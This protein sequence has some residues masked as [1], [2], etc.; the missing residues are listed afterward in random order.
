MEI[1]LT[2]TQC[3]NSR[4]TVA[5]QAHHAVR[6]PAMD[7]KVTDPLRGALLGGRYRI[8]GRLA[9]GGMA[10]VYQARDER[11][12]R[13]VAI[14]II[15][16]DH[17][18]DEAVLDRLA[19]EAKTVA[20]L[21]HPNIVAVYDQGTH[22][23]APYI[24]MEYVRGRTLR[25]MLNDRR[26]LDPSESLAVLEQLLA[27]LAVAH[28]AG[29]V[30][31]DV[32]PENILI[33]PPPNGSG[34]LVDAVVK[35]ADFGLAHAVEIGRNTSGQLLATAEYV[36]PELVADGRADARAD[37]YS[38]GIVL[39]EML[40]GRVPFDGDQ[41]SAV[42]WQHVDEDVPPPSRLIAGLPA[43]LDDVV[44][45]AT[46]RDPAGR[47]RDAAEMLAEIQGAREDVGAL[48]GPTR[49]LAHPTVVVPS[50]T[51]PAERPAWARLPVQRVGG[52]SGRVFTGTGR[53]PGG[54]SGARD[55]MVAAGRR[56]AAYLPEQPLQRTGAW[57]DRT[58]KRLR[59]TA[60]GRRQLTI[61]LVV[62]GLLLMAG[63][64][65]LG[66]GRYTEAPTLLQLTK[67]NAI[68]EATRLGFTVA[69]GPG[70]YSEQVPA[71]TVMQQSPAPGGRIVKGGT[72]TLYL[73]LGLERYPV[74]AV[75]GQ[76]YDY[77]V[78]RMPKQFVVEKVDGY[79]DTLPVGYVVDTD[80]KAETQLKPGS[81][82]KI[83]VVKGAFPVH[84]PTVV[85]RAL[86]D[87]QNEMHAAGF[88]DIEVQQRDDPSKAKDT[89]LDQTPPG[90]EGMASA[91][92][93]HVVLVVSNGPA[94]AMPNVVGQ[95]CYSAS[96][97]LVGM[98]I[99]VSTPNVADP[100]RPGFH[101]SAQSVKEGDPLT[102]GQTVELTC[103]PGP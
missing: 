84:V 52:P 30:H 4:V 99:N 78:A 13:S 95:N 96:S 28:R 57:L 92:G 81:T 102:P 97:Q 55:G 46:T 22:E 48:A 27:A 60:E 59:H 58:S 83:I 15:H 87:A 101:V 71:D 9:R 66:F 68:A 88:T 12:E 1:S 45:R 72:V 49:A 38:A 69:Y 103:D 76:A 42:A 56:L 70:I 54:V 77:A 19:S 80:P 98:G 63:G 65:W 94:L 62:L 17:A 74:P 39:F 3:H 33:A 26:R 25:E 93:Q 20:R 82:V 7:T 23:G 37:V 32:K 89:V 29:L 10:T 47:A 8:L 40:T 86:S 64:W 24:V 44:T 53:R 61:G 51:T 5:L 41:P 90:G 34:D 18:L 85:G 35:V 21:A 6:L 11:L 43:L 79:S 16:P 31:R 100:F 75:A 2:H 91:G 14:K 73:S 36:A 67:D 50:L